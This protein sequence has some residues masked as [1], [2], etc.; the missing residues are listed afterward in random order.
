MKVLNLLHKIVNQKSFT[1]KRE[2]HIRTVRCSSNVYGGKAHLVTGIFWSIFYKNTLKRAQ[3]SFYW[4]GVS[5]VIK[6]WVNSKE[7]FIA[8]KKLSQKHVRTLQTRKPSH[9]FWQ[10]ERIS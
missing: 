4:F 2:I 7:K 5:P 6:N 1:R 8:E 9:P 10:V 3:E